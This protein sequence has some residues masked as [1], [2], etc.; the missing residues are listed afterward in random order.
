MCTEPRLPVIA[1]GVSP[2]RQSPATSSFPMPTTVPIGNGY[3]SISLEKAD[4]AL[5]D[6]VRTSV[7]FICLSDSYFER[8]SIG[9]GAE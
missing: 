5:Y 6:I 9:D 2:T 4:R 1:A 3:F 8:M 7:S